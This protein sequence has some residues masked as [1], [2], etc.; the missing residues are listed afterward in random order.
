MGLA[1]VFRYRNWIKQ[2][3]VKQHCIFDCIKIPETPGGS[4]TLKYVFILVLFWS[5][6]VVVK[7]WMIIYFN[8]VRSYPLY[9]KKS[10]KSCNVNVVQ[11]LAWDKKEKWHR[12]QRVLFKSHLCACT[13]SPGDDG[14]NA[15]IPEFTRIEQAWMVCPRFLLHRWCC[16]VLGS[17]NV[18]PS[19]EAYIS[20]TLFFLHV[21]YNKSHCGC[22][23]RFKLNRGPRGDHVRDQES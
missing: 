17:Q 1:L 14:I 18:H 10:V 4:L 8:A 7:T 19:S 15:H 5:W 22:G 20:R 3:N 13:I 9:I 2:S 12:Y 21:I 16:N 11:S 6:L 23:V